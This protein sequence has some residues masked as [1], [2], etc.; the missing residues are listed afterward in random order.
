MKIKEMDDRIKVILPD[1]QILGIFLYLW[2]E[3]VFGYCMSISGMCG[4]DIYGLVYISAAMGITAFWFIYIMPILK[5]IDDYSTL[6]GDIVYDH[7]A[8]AS[9]DMGPEGFNI[10]DFIKAYNGV[11]HNRGHDKND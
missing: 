7:E 9:L 8:S 5:E 11:S 2:I 10:E 1:F 3:F 4:Y 6:R